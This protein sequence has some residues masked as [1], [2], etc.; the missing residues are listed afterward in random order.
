[1][2]RMQTAIY[3]RKRIAVA[4]YVAHGEEPSWMPNQYFAGLT[5]MSTVSAL[6]VMKE[7]MI[8][9]WQL[10]AVNTIDFMTA[11]A[12]EVPYAVLEIG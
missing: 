3:R 8:T 11:E 1:M 5:N 10:R 6:W 9:L 2:S 4:E 12:A 7:L